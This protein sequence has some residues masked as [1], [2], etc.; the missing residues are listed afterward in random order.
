MYCIKQR[1]S[2]AI[3]NCL[4]N[5][6]FR[7]FAC[8]PNWGPEGVPFFFFEGHSRENNS[9]FR[10]QKSPAFC[11]ALLLAWCSLLLLFRCFF[12]CLFY[13]LLRCLLGCFL[14]RGLLGRCLLCCFLHCQISFTSFG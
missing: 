1:N 3:W 12:R 14:R 13:S 9:R 11:R 7:G 6:T 10:T 8:L 4:S 2:T 5:T